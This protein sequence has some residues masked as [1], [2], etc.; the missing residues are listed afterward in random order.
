MLIVQCELWCRS[1]LRLVKK[2]SR[3]ALALLWGCLSAPCAVVYRRPS[4][5][6]SL[7]APCRGAV[8][9]RSRRLGHTHGGSV[10]EARRR[11]D[12]VDVGGCVCVGAQGRQ[13]RVLVQRRAT[14]PGDD[15]TVRGRG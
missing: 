8:E 6:R 10:C 5:R 3:L 9:A 15:H 13:D 1:R 12:D 11:G 2:A 4:E 7:S 14:N